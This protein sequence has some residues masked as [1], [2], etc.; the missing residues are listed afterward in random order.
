VSLDVGER[1]LC[2]PLAS[3]ARRTIQANAS[4]TSL[5]ADALRASEKNIDGNFASLVPCLAYL[6]NNRR[7]E[8]L[9]P[10]QIVCSREGSRNQ[11]GPRVDS[12]IVTRPLIAIN[13]P[14]PDFRPNSGLRVIQ[15][16]SGRAHTSWLHRWAMYSRMS[17]GPSWSVERWNYCAD[18]TPM[19]SDHGCE[20]LSHDQPIVLSRP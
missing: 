16:L 14:Q 1:H 11:P 5:K 15:Q 7:S 2:V 3:M 6:A 4:N 17:S 19:S 20:R 9:V 10:C 12:Q 8:T 18:Y 13:F